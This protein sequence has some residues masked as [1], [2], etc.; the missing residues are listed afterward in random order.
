MT[1][2][3]LTPWHKVVKDHPDPEIGRR[4]T[5]LPTCCEGGFVGA[6][7]YLSDELVATLSF[8]PSPERVCQESG[9]AE[10]A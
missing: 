1:K 10:I 7:G 3:A 5:P 9:S 6:P 4:S 8:R 2:L